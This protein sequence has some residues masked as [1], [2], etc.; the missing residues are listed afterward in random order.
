MKECKKERKRIIRR[1]ICIYHHGGPTFS[2]N[3]KEGNV[4]YMLH[5][6]FVKHPVSWNHKSTQQA[7]KSRLDPW[8]TSLFVNLWMLGVCNIALTVVDCFFMNFF[9]KFLTCNCS[10]FFLKKIFLMEIHFLLSG[11]LSCT[12][13]LQPFE[14]DTSAT[15]SNKIICCYTILSG[16]NCLSVNC[17]KLG[18]KARRYFIS[19]LVKSSII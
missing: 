15:F 4:L 7:L 14:T 3:S 13:V 10:L 16:R 9:E 12:P 19:V 11:L 2:K 5:L 17:L 6:L 18:R 1:R 8:S